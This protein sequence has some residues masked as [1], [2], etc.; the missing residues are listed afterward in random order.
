MNDNWNPNQGG[1]GPYQEGQMPYQEGQA[2]YPGSQMP[3]QQ[4]SQESYQ[5]QQNAREP[6]QLDISFDND[7]NAMDLNSVLE[8]AP[9]HRGEVYFSNRP[10][11]SKPS[12]A[13]PKKRRKK[14]RSSNIIGLLMIA[15]LA[16]SLIL[17]YVGITFLQDVFA[18]RSSEREAM[19]ILEPGQS[20]NEVIDI[21]SKNR[22]IRQ[23]SLC[24]LYMNLSFY[25]RSRGTDSPKLP[26]Y[27][28]GEYTVSTELG[29]EEMLNHFKSKPQSAETVHLLFSEGFTVK[30]I[31]EKIETNHVATADSLK[32]SMD[33]GQFSQLDFL[34]TTDLSGRYFRYEG[35]L[36][37]DTYQFFV[38]DNVNS[39]LQRFFENF[40][41]KW[42]EKG[43]DKKA[44]AIGMSMDEV[45]T[46]A[47]IIQKEA[48]NNAEMP[49]ISRVLHNRL[50]RSN[51]YPLLECD[52]TRDYVNNNIAVGMDPTTADY[53]GGM[54]STYRVAGLP[55][56][57][58]CNPGLA[59]IEAALAPSEKAE[60]KELYYFQH[61]KNGKIYTAE[62][63][64]EHNA[65][66][67]Q[68]VIAG[69]R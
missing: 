9:A 35:Y 57:P 29:L 55:A 19:L 14:N 54:Y 28:P 11:H 37:P 36:F 67:T 24:K 56:G 10:S 1:Q 60:H 3:Y 25:I 49:L 62:T 53:W 13:P 27:L 23:K 20:T 16:V 21:L 30:Q 34:K 2:P 39:V 59:A 68:I 66:T 40:E 31:I 18:L 64:A 32:R 44:E 26:E 33:G 5:P 22:L 69:L 46:L 17:S 8:E 58:I 4:G 51:V 61:D 45:V 38:N 52:A 50:K 48:A 15:S 6:F 65:N 42:K 63:K 41:K 47:S 12:A 7:Q 43:L